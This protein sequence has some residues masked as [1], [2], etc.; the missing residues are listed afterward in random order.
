[1]HI[2]TPP[3]PGSF[4]LP[5]LDY[6]RFRLE[7]GLTVIVHEDHKAPIVGMT[8][9]YHVGS[10]NEP[11]GMTGFAHL[12]EHLMFSGSENHRNS[13]FEP[14]S[15]VG[16]TDLNGTTWF[17]RTNYLVTVPTTALDMAMWMESDRMGHLLGAIGQEE[18]EA[19]RGVVKNEKRQNQNA[20]FGRVDEVIQNAV[21]P[22]N[23]PY[24]HITIGSMEDIDAATLEN[25]QHWFRTHYGAANATLVLAGDITPDVA[26]EKA[27][28][29]FGHI[30]PGPPPDRLQPWIAPLDQIVRQEMTDN[31]PDTRIFRRWNVPGFD[32][33]DS[34]LLQLGASV[35][36]GNRG[37]R[38]RERLVR[39]ESMATNVSAWTQAFALAGQFGVTVDLVRGVDAAAVEAVIDDEVAR[40]IKEGPAQE[41]LD[42]VRHDLLANFV[43][44][45]E[46][47]GGMGG[48]AGV[49][50]EGQVLRGNPLARLDDLRAM[51]AAT[52][53]DVR[54]ACQRWVNGKHYT[55]VVL[56]ADREQ[57][58]AA[59]VALR[60]P[61]D[62]RPE[63]MPG[64]DHDYSA[65]ESP[66]DRSAGV[67][68]VL[69]YPNVSFPPVSR[70][71]LSNGI[72]V[73]FA[74][75]CGAG[76]VEL[77]ILL[78]DGRALDVGGT[79][80]LE[81]V[82]WA[83]LPEG[84]TTRDAAAIEAR[85]QQLGVQL[86]GL[87]MSALSGRLE[88][89]LELFVDVL[90]RPAFRET[91]LARLKPRL[92]SGVERALIDPNMV[93]RTVL[94][95]LLF[96][97]EHPYGAP[98]AGRGTKE[99]I[100]AIDGATLA[101][102]HE[103]NVRPDN[104]RVFA[105]GDVRFDDLV[106]MLEASFG[107]WSPPGVQL[108]RGVIPRVTRASTPRLV[109]VDRP[110]AGQSVIMG[111][112][113][114]EVPEGELPLALQIANGVFGR[115]FS[116]RLNMNLREAKHW[117]YGAYSQL[118]ADVVQ[119][120]FTMSAAVQSDSTAPALVE[121]IAEVETITGV[122]PPTTAE[123]DLAKA[124]E[125]RTLPGRF[126]S[127]AEVAR[128]LSVNEM[129]RRP[130]DYVQTLKHRIE[131]LTTEEVIAAACD[132]FTASTMTWVVVGDLAQIEAPLRA[133]GLDVTIV[134][135]RGRALPGHAPA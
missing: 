72:E 112:T 96:G 114:L 123:I 78:S 51:A 97:T 122:R 48:K 105:S 57:S 73:T 46:Y 17:D 15:H 65:A 50:A 9:W 4:D 16:A 33:P 12:F 34:V 115:N 80:G 58:V 90:R 119:A 109:L 55:L 113:V 91:D 94:L 70:A 77:N 67:P 41:Q 129:F 100:E 36:G 62:D 10:A 27:A 54:V 107:A 89:S 74:E 93:A 82:L 106:E 84:T 130:D 25:V 117:A 19:Q 18:L 40:F 128:T 104:M 38:L 26:R 99:T 24:H 69:D 79:P 60:A 102:F 22:F 124:Q 103:S 2:S 49:L 3:K 28:R 83:M 75:R 30:P 1:M 133:I 5:T 87:S 56:P 125:V 37:S 20:P 116:S 134:D 120:R 126:E 43:R 61:L 42:S 39:T 68:A 44:S 13:Y 127:S 95:G 71:A 76:L 52:V 11:K 98:G 7:N 64:L 35:F 92:L 63:P 47:V 132:L 81:N 86:S 14:F 66:L 53:E 23:H 121:M 118:S 8:L 32:H 29:Y 45:L 21:Y 85:R 111:G 101:R 131:A 135:A 31:I 59:A 108:S 88:E 110:G 6:A